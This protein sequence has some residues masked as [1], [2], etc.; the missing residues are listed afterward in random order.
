M[1]L[2]A[3]SRI[4]FHHNRILLQIKDGI[5]LFDCIHHQQEVAQMISSDF[6]GD[7]EDPVVANKSQQSWD[8]ESRLHEMERELGNEY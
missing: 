7:Q 6:P 8:G 5:E 3:S 4:S 1:G 2:F